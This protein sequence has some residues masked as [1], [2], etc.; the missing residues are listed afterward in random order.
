[1]K[2]D[3]LFVSL[4]LIIVLVL[5]GC[6]SG[7]DLGKE[8]KVFLNPIHEED[9]VVDEEPEVEEPFIN[10]LEPEEELLSSKII[11][12]E[13]FSH[14]ITLELKKDDEIKFILN[15]K[16]NTIKLMKITN[17]SVKL[18]SGGFWF[19]VKLGKARQ[20]D[21]EKD[22]FL[23][24]QLKLNSIIGE[25]SELCI[26]KFYGSSSINQNC[27][28][29][30]LPKDNCRIYTDLNFISS[31]NIFLNDGRSLSI[32]IWKENDA[33]ITYS[34]LERGFK[35]TEEGVPFIESF[36]QMN[37]P[38][39]TLNI[40]CTNMAVGSPGSLMI[41][42]VSPKD[43]PGNNH[44]IPG[45]VAPSLLYHELTHSF[46]N[47]QNSFS[48]FSE[49]TARFVSYLTIQYIQKK[50]NNQ[51]LIMPYGVDDLWGPGRH[52]TDFSHSYE[53]VKGKISDFDEQRLYEGIDYLNGSNLGYLFLIDVYFIIGEDALSNVYGELYERLKTNNTIPITQEE[54][55]IAI[56][57]NTPND[58]KEQIIELIDQRLG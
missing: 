53:N 4:F 51:Q 9:E 14:G 33:D 8:K 42:C 28:E 1:M 52:T 39:E 21:F 20:Y 18:K 44:F 13:V 10:E 24:I 26:E 47:S 57:S 41:G 3:I 46:W 50:I 34:L 17:D 22:G 23:D 7:L 19:D 25:V 12:E 43:R 54:I 36:L 29:S 56:I 27:A 58:K 32:D 16:E 48:W 31:T 55:K 38:C 11:S 35:L 5:S 30:V 37:Y 45:L 6:Q 40:V 49:G 2:R 15:G